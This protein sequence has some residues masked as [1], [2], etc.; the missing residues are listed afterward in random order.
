VARVPNA[1]YNDIQAWII[2]RLR[3]IS[4]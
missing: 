2:C 3:V 4:I 1:K